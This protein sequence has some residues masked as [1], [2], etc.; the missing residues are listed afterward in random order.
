MRQTAAGLN[1]SWLLVLGLVLLLAGSAG[2]AIGAGLLQS[3]GPNLGLRLD[4]P[5][6]TTLVIAGNA[7]ALFDAP[8]MVLAV[9]VVAVGLLLLGVAWL[10]AQVPRS[11][12]ARPFRLHD[13]PE[14]GLT[15]CSAEVLADAAAKDIERLPDVLKASAV[16]R[17][18]SAE[19]ELTVR[20]V[21]SDRADLPRLIESI[22]HP[23]ADNLGT[24][25]DARLQRLAV[26]IEIDRLRPQSDHAVLQ[27]LASGQVRA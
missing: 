27:P 11:N 3:I 22:Q 18:T 25:M 9:G 20:V 12:A 19:P 16:L 21:A 10:I 23:V 14:T 1:R 26:Q 7:A 8:L 13:D 5:D 24:A 15:T 2:L 6:P 17:G 4:Q